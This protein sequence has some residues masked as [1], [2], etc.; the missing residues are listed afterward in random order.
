LKDEVTK[1]EL[2]NLENRKTVAGSTEPRHIGDGKIESG[3]IKLG[4]KKAG[5]IEDGK[6]EV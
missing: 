1:E 4:R 3:M 2:G 5:Q 6:T